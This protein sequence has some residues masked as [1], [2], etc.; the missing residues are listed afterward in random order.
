M[1]FIDTSKKERTERTK[2]FRDLRRTKF[3]ESETKMIF[4][5]F[6]HFIKNKVV[7]KKRDTMTFLTENPIKG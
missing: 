1:I 3:S 4:E 5:Y 6:K 2:E 7:P